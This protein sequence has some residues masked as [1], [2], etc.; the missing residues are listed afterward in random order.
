MSGRYHRDV[1]DHKSHYEKKSIEGN[2]THPLVELQQSVT[3]N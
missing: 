2:S 1:A 3:L